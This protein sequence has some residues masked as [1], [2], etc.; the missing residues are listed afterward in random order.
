MTVREVGQDPPVI[1]C[2]AETRCPST[3]LLPTKECVCAAAEKVLPLIKSPGTRREQLGLMQRD[4][5]SKGGEQSIHP[6]KPSF[7]SSAAHGNMWGLFSIQEK[8]TGKSMPFPKL[9]SSSPLQVMQ[10]AAHTGVPRDHRFD[11]K[12][13]WWEFS[14]AAVRGICAA[15]TRQR[16]QCV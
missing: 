4:G 6:T 2:L 14:P 10:S 5:E 7:L 12:R 11:Q 15:D 3:S 16:K 8:S 1:N 9:C 13:V